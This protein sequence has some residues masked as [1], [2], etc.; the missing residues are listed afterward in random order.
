MWIKWKNSWINLN[1]VSV[2]ERCEFS[3]NIK[4]QLASNGW[5]AEFVCSTEGERQELEE[6]ISK[7]LN[8]DNLWWETFNDS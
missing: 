5:I 3:Y 6:K 2:V 7:A 8:R 1:S 4:T